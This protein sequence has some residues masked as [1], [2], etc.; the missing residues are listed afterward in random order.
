M[1]VPDAF[2]LSDSDQRSH[3][4]VSYGEVAFSYGQTGGSVQVS[5][6]ATDLSSHQSKQAVI[7]LSSEM[8]GQSLYGI[9]P[10]TAAAVPIKFEKFDEGVEPKELVLLS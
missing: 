1:V 10:F 9:S 7:L 6:C 3:N 8:C 2:R 5:F 4:S